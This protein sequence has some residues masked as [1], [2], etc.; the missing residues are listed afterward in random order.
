MTKSPLK[1]FVAL[2]SFGRESDRSDL[3]GILPSNQ[4]R[5]TKFLMNKR[6]CAF[7]IAY[8]EGARVKTLFDSGPL[9]AKRSS[10]DSGGKVTVHD[11]VRWEYGERKFL[12]PIRAANLILTH[13]K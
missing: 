5:Q 11:S 1:R 2:V 4:S 3:L 6:P 9:D 13:V 10:A 7:L 8:G 12:P